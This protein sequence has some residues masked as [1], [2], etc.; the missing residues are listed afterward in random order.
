[1]RATV[2]VL[3]AVVAMP[4]PALAQQPGWPSPIHDEQI[5]WKVLAEQV[6]IAATGDGNAV[7]WDVQGWLGGDYNRLWMKSEGKGARGGHDGDFEL[8]ALYGRL[9]SPFWD[10]QAG[11][12]YERQLGPGPGLQRV[13]L[14]LGVQGLAPYWF[15]LE[16]ALFISDDGDISARIEASYDLLITQRLILQPDFEVDLAVQSV[17][18]WGVGSGVN[19]L[20]LALRL[21]YELRRELAPYLGVEWSRLFGETAELAAAGGDEPREL[22]VLGGVRLWF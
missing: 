6:E 14:V 3:L 18:E 16:P 12:R 13:H 9:V 1:M 15:E 7:V 5:F 10:V 11:L 20:A 8:Q 21:R 4:L 19:E 22:A 2:L 17:E